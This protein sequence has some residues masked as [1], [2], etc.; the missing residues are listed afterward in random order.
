MVARFY[1]RRISLKLRKTGCKQGN[2]PFT[3]SPSFQIK[4]CLWLARTWRFTRGA[5]GSTLSLPAHWAGPAGDRGLALPVPLRGASRSLCGP[6]APIRQPRFPAVLGTKTQVAVSVLKRSAPRLLCKGK[7]APVWAAP[8]LPRSRAPSILRSPL[9]SPSPPPG[10]AG[11]PW[12]RLSKG[13]FPAGRHR[14]A[15]EGRASRGPRGAG[16]LRGHPLKGLLHQAGAVSALVVR[17]GWFR[18]FPRHTP[19]L[20]SNSP[21]GGSPRK[22]VLC[23]LRVHRE[24]IVV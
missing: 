2:L 22:G 12:P 7:G 16:G 21:G 11:R 4:C 10:Q 1:L 6:T 20:C 19:P 9:K 18:P 13:P 24:K 3:V 5:W 15:G 8:V 17:P 14:A 23:M